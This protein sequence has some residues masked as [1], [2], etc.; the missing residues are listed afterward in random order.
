MDNK[1][2]VFG[3]DVSKAWLVIGDYDCAVLLKIANTPAHIAQWLS[4]IPQGSTVAMEATGAYHQ[5]LAA[6][7]HAASMRVFVLNPR[8]LKHYAEAIGQRGKTDPVDSRMLARYAM[9]EQAKLVSWEP[10]PTASDQLSQLLQRRDRLVSAGQM[11]AQSLA[12]V[13]TLKA[14][15]EEL[16]ASVK[17]MIRN[18]AY[19]RGARTHPATARA[20]Q[21][22]Q[23]H[24]WGR[25]CGGGSVGGRA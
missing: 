19:A 13:N 20:A 15:R 6:M 22:P 1:P 10:P 11:L 24:R 9:H 12:G 3:V 25:L 7:A 23:Q 2:R 4:S 16:V 21:A 8:A 18:T 17:R 5:V 14:A